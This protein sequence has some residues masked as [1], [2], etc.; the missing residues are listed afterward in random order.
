VLLR[1]QRHIQVIDGFAGR[2]VGGLVDGAE[3][4]QA[5]IAKMVARRL[6]VHEA[7]N[8]IAELPVFENLVGDYASELARAG[9]SEC[10]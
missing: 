10:A 1:R 7:D 8:L 3:Q 5:A 9:E 6:V 4:R 2:D